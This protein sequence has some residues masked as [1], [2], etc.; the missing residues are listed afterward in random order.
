MKPEQKKGK[1]KKETKELM[2]KINGHIKDV[3]EHESASGGEF[4]QA[5]NFDP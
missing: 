2:E 3:S 5:N 1:S 4:I